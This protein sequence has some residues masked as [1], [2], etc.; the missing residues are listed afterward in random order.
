MARKRPDSI[1]DYQRKERE[2]EAAASASQPDGLTRAQQDDRTTHIR[3]GQEAWRRHKDDATWHDWLAIGQAL[4]IGRQDAM[5][6]AGTNQPIGSRYNTAFG[7]W[8]V[9]HRFDDIDKGDR[10][11]LFDVMDNLPAIE[12]W[13]ATLPSTLRLRLNH[14]N[15]ILRKWK[16]ATVVKPPKEPKRRPP[17]AGRPVSGRAGAL[18]IGKDRA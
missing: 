14:P 3:R 11:R 2:R 17:K 13:R 8:L 4:S 6:D 18:R 12:E 1:E 9:R 10:S 5:A 15:S 7:D 16:A